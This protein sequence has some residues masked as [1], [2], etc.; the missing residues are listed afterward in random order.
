MQHRKNITKVT[1][2]YISDTRV[3]QCNNQHVKQETIMPVCFTPFST[4]LLEVGK[5]SL[6]R[7]AQ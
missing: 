4:S 5:V 2:A 3:Y 7:A 1:V 6:H